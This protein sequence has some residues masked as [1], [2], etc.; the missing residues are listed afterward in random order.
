MDIHRLEEGSKRYS[1]DAELS[2]SE[3]GNIPLEVQE[4]WYWYG[5]ESYDGGGEMLMRIGDF[6][7]LY[8]LG[9]CSCYGPTDSLDLNGQGQTLATIEQ[10]CTEEHYEEDVKILVEAARKKGFK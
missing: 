9:H 2:E 10:G 5:Y 8:N 7:W 3:I 1:Y 6:F 4:V